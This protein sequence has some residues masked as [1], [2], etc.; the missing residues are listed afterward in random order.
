MVQIF[1]IYS[2]NKNAPAF[3]LN[4]VKLLCFK[5]LLT[6]FS[7]MMKR[8]Y[9]SVTNLHCSHFSRGNTQHQWVI[10]PLFF[11]LI[12]QFFR[13]KD[14]EKYRERIRMFC[15]FFRD[16]DFHAGGAQRIFQVSK[17]RPGVPSFYLELLDHGGVMG[18]KSPR[19][20]E[21]AMDFTWNS[22]TTEE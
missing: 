20:Q 7:V 9:L 21:R 6:L 12:N 17:I 2:C 15:Y 10:R 8:E 16:Q 11:M 5:R 4:L 22:Q 18:P 14:W 3:F 13:I 1:R 19:S